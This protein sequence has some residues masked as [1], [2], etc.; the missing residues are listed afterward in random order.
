MLC[1][2]IVSGLRLQPGNWAGAY[3]C[4]GTENREAALRF[5]VGGPGNPYGGNVEVKVVDPSA[6]PYF[7]TATI[8]GLA[9]DGI[10]ENAVLPA[11]TK[12]DPAALSDTERS[13]AGI[14]P[15]VNVASAHHCG[16][17]YFATTAQHS[18]RSRRRRRGRGPPFRARA[19]RPP[20]PRTI[21]RQV[22]DGMERV[23]VSALAEH[24]AGV[25]LIDQHV[26][27]CWLAAGDRSSVR[28]CPQRG[29]HRAARRLRLRIRHPT[30]LRRA[31]SLR[32]VAR[33]A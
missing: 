28:E 30:R 11:E 29:Q 14:T 33:S 8:L 6:N 12:V 21:G 9:L 17:G 1:G 22:P 5:V 24:I 20:Q 19:L 27:G 7:A 15:T 10:T 32:A 13:R 25:P 18:R 31:R 26:H 4:W 3:V 23:T 2:S 16:T